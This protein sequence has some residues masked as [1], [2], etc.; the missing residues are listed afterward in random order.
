MRISDWSSDVCSSDLPPLCRAQGAYQCRDRWRPARSGCDPRRGRTQIIGAGGRGDAPLR[1]W[2][3][4]HPARRP[5][6]RRS[7]GGRGGGAHPC[8]RSARLSAAG[9]AE[10]NDGRGELALPEAIRGS[11]L[12]GAVWFEIDGKIGPAGQC[13]CSKCRKRSGTDGNAVFYTAVHSF[14]RLSGEDN[15]ASFTVQI[16]SAHVCTPVTNAQLVCLTL[17]EKKKR[18]I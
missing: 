4:P 15:I 11:C 17:L 3:Y 1:A 6:H 9:A 8:R 14:R 10:L 12:C 5:H 7:D 2:L 16:G 18:I 13:H